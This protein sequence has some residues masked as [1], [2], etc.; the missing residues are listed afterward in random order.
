MTR[1]KTA[2]DILCEQVYED[3]KEQMRAYFDNLFDE[4]LTT[5]IDADTDELID[6]QEFLDSMETIDSEYKQINDGGLTC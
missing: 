1:N 6:D 3:N 5:E 2:F 4:I